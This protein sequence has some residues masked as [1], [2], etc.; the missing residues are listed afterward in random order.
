M[1]F[2]LM[3]LIGVALAIVLPVQAQEAKR[4]PAQL[5]AP[6]AAKRDAILAA[7]KARDLAA[8]NRLIGPGD[9]VY[10][11]GDIGDAIG[12]W[13]DSVKQ[14][15]D[16]PRYLVGVLSMPCVITYDEDR[17]QYW[18]PAAMEFDWK[19][20]TPAEKQALEALYDRKVDDWYVEGR[21][22]G[23]YVGWRAGIDKNGAW[24]AFV[25]GD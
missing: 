21:A 3:L 12:Y 7:A 10:S 16:I 1:I 22:K 20:L 19:N 8:L 25:A 13:Q 23:Y 24:S 4:C 11:F 18:W 6:V 17:Q 15:I 2:R 14:G 9:F 5:P